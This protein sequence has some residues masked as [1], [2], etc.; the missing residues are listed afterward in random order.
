M[1]NAIFLDTGLVTFRSQSGKTGKGEGVL[2]GKAFGQRSVERPRN[3]W[4]RI[5][6]GLKKIK[7]AT[8]I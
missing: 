8:W 7:H 6:I 1:R 4:K 3:R 5:K 2:A